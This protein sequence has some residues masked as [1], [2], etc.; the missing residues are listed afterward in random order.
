MNNKVF[1]SGVHLL[2]YCMI[3][4][5]S[6]IFLLLRIN[7]LYSPNFPFCMPD[8]ISGPVWFT[9]LYSIPGIDLAIIILII[10]SAAFFREWKKLKSCDTFHE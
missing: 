5:T 3:G 4:C 10:C 6:V 2:I 1:V 9:V 7:Y 8:T